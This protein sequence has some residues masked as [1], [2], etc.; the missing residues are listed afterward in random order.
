MKEQ[1]QKG[2]IIPG[3]EDFIASGEKLTMKDHARA[4]DH[5]IESLGR[6][7]LEAMQQPVNHY[8]FYSFLLLFRAML[9]D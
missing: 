5:L 2:D 1:T 4:L 8:D 7:P 3:V 9:Q 6:L